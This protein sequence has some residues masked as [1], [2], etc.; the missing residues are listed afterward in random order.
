MKTLKLIFTVSCL[1]VVVA[2]IYP[3]VT[4]YRKVLAVGRS[5]TFLCIDY[6]V[7]GGIR[8]CLGVFNDP[9]FL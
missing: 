6:L 3:H 7:L 9:M 8:S 2:H 5:H 1:I 4:G